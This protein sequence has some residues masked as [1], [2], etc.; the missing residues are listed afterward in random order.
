MKT[1]SILQWNS[2]DEE[3]PENI[4]DLIRE[5][6]PD[7]ACL[8]ELTQN[9]EKQNY[10]DVPKFLAEKLGWNM[11]FHMAQY[12][13]TENGD[14]IQGNAIFSR[15]TL[16]NTSHQFIQDLKHDNFDDYADEGRV[17]IGATV[18]LGGESVEVFTTQMSYTHGFTE[19]SQKSKEEENLLKY[20]RDKRNRCFLTGD[21]NATEDSKFINHLESIMH[22]AGPNYSQKTWTTKPFNY[23]GFTATE[24]N[25]RLDHVFCSE[26][27]EIVSTK[28]FQTDFSDHLPILVEF[29][30]I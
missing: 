14:Q 27:I 9:Y 24:L 12:W 2:W 3:K 25:W 20:I 22:N 8:Q 18:D 4:L 26:D 7:I 23:E 17:C 19:T 1:Y 21:F 29:S 13:P 5:I 11:H 28:I 16:T 15:H 30:L 6:N 10:L